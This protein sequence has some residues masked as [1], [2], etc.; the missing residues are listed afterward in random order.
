M[1]AGL[2]DEVLAQ[3]DIRESGGY[4]RAWLDV[5]VES[6]ARCL[7]ALTYIA[8]PSNENFLGSAPLEAMVEQ[9][10]RAVGASGENLEYVL[11]LDRALAK[12][13]IEDA[14]VQELASALREKGQS[15]GR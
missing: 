11:E 7:T 15:P 10:W 2:R 3:L 9:I 1:E 5:E 8:P 14:H 13:Q 12:L 4:E 6:E